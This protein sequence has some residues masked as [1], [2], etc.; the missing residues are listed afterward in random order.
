MRSMAPS[1]WSYLKPSA[2]TWWL[3][4]ADVVRLWRRLL[5]IPAIARISPRGIEQAAERKSGALRGGKTDRG[6]HCNRMRFIRQGV[7]WRPSRV[8]HRHGFR[9]DPDVRG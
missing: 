8:A 5:T 2:F 3:K 4:G 9:L 1:G 7:L 6:E